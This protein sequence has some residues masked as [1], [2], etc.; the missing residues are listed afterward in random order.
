MFSKKFVFIHVKFHIRIV[1]DLVWFSIR[2]RCDMYQGVIEIMLELLQCKRETIITNEF[3]QSYHKYFNPEYI[4]P[5]TFLHKATTD[6]TNRNIHEYSKSKMNLK[7]QF[8][9]DFHWT[10]FFRSS[11]FWNVN[12]Y[13]LS[14][15]SSV[16]EGC[17]TLKWS[18]LN[19]PICFWRFH[20]RTFRSTWQ[21]REWQIMLPWSPAAAQICSSCLLAFHIEG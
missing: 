5:L 17:L 7:L 6:S 11:H 20:W 10:K 16:V 8:F 21:D 4:W 12:D 2:C 13:S 18:H 19:V 14:R 3:I 1:N 15:G 9:V